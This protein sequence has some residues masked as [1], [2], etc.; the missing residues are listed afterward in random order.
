MAMDRTTDR[1]PFSID[2]LHPKMLLPMTALL[3]TTGWA[4][5]FTIGSDHYI[6]EPFEGLRLPIRQN[7]LLTTGATKARPWQSAHQYG[8]AVD[9]ACHRVRKNGVAIIPEWK[10][11]LSAPWDQL[12]SRAIAAGL[13]VPIE[14]DKGH[15]CSPDWRRYI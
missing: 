14:W 12:K 1:Y 9:F 13:D 4:F 15:V 7:H 8:L 5:V 11:P 3:E 10:W 2:D 6:F